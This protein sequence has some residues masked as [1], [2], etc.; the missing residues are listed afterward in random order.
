MI[1]GWFV[2]V[3]VLIGAAG[4]QAALKAHRINGKERAWWMLLLLSWMPC[5]CWVL[6]QFIEQW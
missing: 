2:P 6:A 1:M 3:G 5:L 4:T